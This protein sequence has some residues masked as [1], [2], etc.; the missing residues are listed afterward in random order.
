[1]RD[2]T[3]GRTPIGNTGK[4]DRIDMNITA[5]DALNVMRGWIGFSRAEQ[6]HHSIVDIY[7]SYIPLP[8]DYTVTYQDAYCD[9]TV[10]AVFITLDAVSLIGGTECGVC[11]HIE[12]FKK[13]GIWKGRVRPLPGWIVTYDM[14][15]N[16]VPDHIGL[17]ETVDRNIIVVIEGNMAKEGIVGRRY[18][19]WDDRRICGYAA[20]AY[21]SEKDEIR[22][23]HSEYK[24]ASPG[25][26]KRSRIRNLYV[27]NG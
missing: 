5:K 15:R 8:L 13:S 3:V 20:P 16:G 26:S 17:V 11:R 23:E 24:C 4:D 2:Y 7:N 27:I 21:S 18:I 1:M 25:T 19:E 12:I 22:D 14:D 9:A 10:S 6:T